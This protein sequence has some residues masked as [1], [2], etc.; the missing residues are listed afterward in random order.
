ME[1]RLFDLLPP[2]I[3]TYQLKGPIKTLANSMILP[4]NFALTVEPLGTPASSGKKQEILFHQQAMLK[5]LIASNLVLMQDL[6]PLILECSSL[7]PLQPCPS[8]LLVARHIL[9][10]NA[11]LSHYWALVLE[12][13][14]AQQVS[15]MLGK[16][17]KPPKLNN[18]ETT[19]FDPLQTAKDDNKVQKVIKESKSLRN[20]PRSSNPGPSGGIRKNSFSPNRGQDGRFRN[21]NSSNYNSNNN[22]NFNKSSK[23]FP[24]KGGNRQQ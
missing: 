13:R 24:K 20:P 14:N 11:L 21:N 2:N 6:A 23:P 1:D 17:F 15:Y 4:E 19:I 9:A 10:Q 22:S 12:K 16:K 8:E 3:N 18:K 5:K 7:D